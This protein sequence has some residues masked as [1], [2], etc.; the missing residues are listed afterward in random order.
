MI[1]T[2]PKHLAFKY[3]EVWEITEWKDDC[4]YRTKNTGYCI[5]SPSNI[6]PLNPDRYQLA[7]ISTHLHEGDTIDIILLSPEYFE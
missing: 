3:S 6:N 4:V 5:E 2:I 7:T 1:K